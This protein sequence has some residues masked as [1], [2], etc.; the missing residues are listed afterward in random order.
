MEIHRFQLYPKKC[1]LNAQPKTICPACGQKRFVCYTDITTGQMLN[2]AVGK[3]DRA[4]KCAYHYTPKMYFAN[5]GKAPET[6]E[7]KPLP[8]LKRVYLSP[9]ALDRYSNTNTHSDL[10]TGLARKIDST[11]LNKAFELYRI[12]TGNN[13]ETIFPQFDNHNKLCYAKAVY[14]DPQTAKRTSHIFRIK[15]DPP[16]GTYLEQ[17]LFGLHLLPSC[18]KTVCVV[19]SEKSAII[20]SI[21]NPRSIWMATG[22]CNNLKLIQALQGKIVKLYPDADKFDEW[23]EKAQQYKHLFHRLIICD[24]RP[25]M[26]PEEIADGYDIQT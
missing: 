10:F 9:T 7:M 23:K 18:P 22:G 13:N 6:G 20:A 14:Y 21:H 11:E 16:E 3:C 4:N 2:E 5:G 12:R 17:C 19:E 15:Y 8:Q 1:G 26:T 24:L 25:Q